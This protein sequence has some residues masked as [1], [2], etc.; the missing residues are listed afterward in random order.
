M[1][2]A[3]LPATRNRDLSLIVRVVRVG[4]LAAATVLAWA[5][6][7]AWVP[8]WVQILAALVVVTAASLVATRPADVTLRRHAGAYLGHV[9]LAAIKAVLITL[10]RA[11]V[12]LLLLAAAW[13]WIEPQ[14]TAW[15][16]GAVHSAAASVTPSVPH[17]PAIHWPWSH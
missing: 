12:V 4:V 8:R 14:V 7:I 11:L 15:I 17:L 2:A 13:G 1:T 5:A 9:F 10:V 3:D 16:G 6:V